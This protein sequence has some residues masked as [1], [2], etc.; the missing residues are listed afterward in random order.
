MSE[1]STGK[2]L[3]LSQADWDQVHEAIQVLLA[4]LDDQVREQLPAIRSGPSRAAGRVCFLNSLRQFRWPGEE[5]GITE[6]VVVEVTFTPS[7]ADMEVRV[8]GDICGG[9]TGHVYYEIEER[10]VSASR[11]AV[12]AA[13][14][15]IAGELSQQVEV[16][17]NALCERRPP[18]DY[19]SG[20]LGIK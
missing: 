13:A 19:R 4:P 18:P 1:T 6:A 3:A 8:S 17:V 12:Y 16:V 14:C 5:E 10:Q 11:D 7:S 9:E 2:T 15:E 20:V